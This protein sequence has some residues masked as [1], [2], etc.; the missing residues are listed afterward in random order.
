M[1]VAR[2]ARSERV[3]DADAHE[4]QVRHVDE[5]DDIA[6]HEG[7]ERPCDGRHE[8]KRGSVA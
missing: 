5:S 8:Q 3:D 1:L 2:A 6:E 4:Q 7:E